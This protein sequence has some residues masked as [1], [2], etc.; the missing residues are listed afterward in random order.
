MRPTFD[1]VIIGGGIMGCSTAFELAHRGVKVAVLEKRGICT[2][3]TG[4]SSAIIRQHYSNELTA[5]MA[6]YGLH[7]FQD[8]DA[9][10][11]GECAFEQTGFVAL[12][13]AA[14]IPGLEANAALQRRVGINTELLSPEALR[15]IIPGMATDDV[16]AAA[17][18]PEGGYADPHLATTAYAEAAGRF[19]TKVYGNAEVTGVR[20]AGDRV[21]GVDTSDGHFAAPIVINCAGP[22]GAAVAGMTGMTAPI[23]ACRVQVATFRRPTEFGPTHPVVLDFIHATYFRPETGNLTLVGLI[24]P[25]E[26]DDVVDPD[27]YAERIDQEFVETVG[28]RWARRYPAMDASVSTGGYTGLYA[29]TPD[30]HPIVDEAPQG[31]GCYISAGFSGH[32]FKLAPAVGLMTAEMVLGVEQPRFSPD[33]FRLG[34]FAEADLIHGQYEYSITG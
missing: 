12:V 14:D 11:G 24:D 7:V 17:Y 27:D 5:A 22:W 15:E 2:G 21:V 33:M 9:H 25:A 30:W 31:S 28:E 3:S 13:P 29:V 23:D 10:V 19:G 8:F 1:A 20:F 16:V 18:E 32:G 34:R 6:L 26:A 4:R